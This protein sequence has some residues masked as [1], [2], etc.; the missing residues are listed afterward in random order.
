MDWANLLLLAASLTFLLLQTAEKNKQIKHFLFAAF[1]G[2]MCMVSLQN[3]SA[4]SLGAYSYLI[5]LGACATCNMLW[6]IARALFRKENAITWVHIN[7]ALAIALMVMLNQTNALLNGLNIPAHPLSIIQSGMNEILNLLSST[8]LMLSLWEAIR[9]FAAKTKH[10]KQQSVVFA[11]AFLIGISACTIL[12]TFLEQSVTESIMVYLVAFSAVAIML[13]I[14]VVL[15]L[16]RNMVKHASSTTYLPIYTETVEDAHDE[17]DPQAIAI[18]DEL[19]YQRKCYLQPKLKML[20]IA[21]AGNIPEYKVSRVIRQH[22]NAVN[23]NR[24]INELRIDHAKALMCSSEGANWSLLVVSL[25]SGFTSLATFN[26]AFKASVGELPSEYRRMA[27]TD[28]D[29]GVLT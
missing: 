8:V 5:G 20:D 14:Q 9:A 28:L 6:L 25:E 22:Y 27:L 10:E 13:S 3:L 2:S 17:L 23:F 29:R 26:R 19:I 12:P 15:Y 4:E 11:S 18:V 16:Q 7:V 24:F 1:C 21:K